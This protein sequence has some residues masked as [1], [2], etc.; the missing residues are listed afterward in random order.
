MPFI[1]MI[2]NYSNYFN[3]FFSFGRRPT[4]LLSHG[5]YFLGGLMTLFSPYFWLICCARFFVGFAH[6]AISHLPYLIGKPCSGYHLD[7]IF[8]IKKA[9][10]RNIFFSKIAIEYCG[11]KTRTY[12]LLIVMISNTLASVAV[13]AL[14]MFLPNWRA[15]TCIAIIPIPLVIVGSFFGLVP[16]SLSWLIC[17]G[18]IDEVRKATETVARINGQSLE[19][20]VK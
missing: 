15:L 3:F 10:Y 17:E 20:N 1:F 5:I 9:K 12:P 14:A 11:I 19:V 13:P 4:V 16:E 2:H 6:L 18:K 7:G 8:L